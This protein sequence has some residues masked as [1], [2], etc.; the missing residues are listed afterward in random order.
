MYASR[1]PNPDSVPGMSALRRMPLRGMESGAC[2]ADRAGPGFSSGVRLRLASSGCMR[3]TAVPSRS[4]TVL[5]SPKYRLI[6][7]TLS[8]KRR[9]SPLR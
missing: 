7:T 2:H 5:F 8:S 3:A 1:A 4:E 9:A 6:W